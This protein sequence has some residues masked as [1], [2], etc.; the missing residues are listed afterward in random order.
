MK[1]KTII[2]ASLIGVGALGIFLAN[3]FRKKAV[4][5]KLIDNTGIKE[6]GVFFIGGSNPS[7]YT[8]NAD[9]GLVKKE[10]QW[11]GGK[12]TK[13]VVATKSLGADVANEIYNLANELKDYNFKKFG[14][15]TSNIVIKTVDGKTNQITYN[16]KVDSETVDPDAVAIINKIESLI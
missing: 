7:N 9:G 13:K 12:P 16:P 1:K 6:V 4:A 11:V 3:R 15:N 14:S 10:V 8:L 2:V 5:K